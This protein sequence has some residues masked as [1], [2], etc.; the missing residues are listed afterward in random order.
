MSGNP[1]CR[2]DPNTVLQEHEGKRGLSGGPPGW[3]GR[4]E[5]QNALGW[6]GT[7]GLWQ[8]TGC[9][10]GRG[11][12]AEQTPPPRTASLQAAATGLGIR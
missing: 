8:D 3:R 5:G 1:E 4:H 9:W 2:R 7:G 6:R 11:A 10:G 12:Q